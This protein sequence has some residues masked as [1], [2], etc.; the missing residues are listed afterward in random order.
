MT[1]DGEC[2]YEVIKK[3]VPEIPCKTI[4]CKGI[5]CEGKNCKKDDECTD[6]TCVPHLCE[7]DDCKMK[8]PK[9]ACENCKILPCVGKGCTDTPKPP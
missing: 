4:D 6:D 5:T 7:G 8:I 2:H 1:C 9:E 3:F